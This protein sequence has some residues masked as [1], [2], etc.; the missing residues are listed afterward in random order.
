[1]GAEPRPYEAVTLSPDGERAVLQVDNPENQDLFIYDFVRDTPTRFTFDP[2]SDS[3]PIWTP[4]GDRVVFTSFRDR[5]LNLYWKAADGTG[6]V[7]RLT[8][9]ENPQVPSAVSPDGMTLLFAEIRG[10][11]ATDV[12]A[13]SLSGEHAVEWL[14]ES[15]ANEAYAEVSPDSRWVAY[16]SDESGLPEVYVRSYPNVDDAKRQ[17]SRNGGIAPR[18]GPDSNEVF[19]QTSDGPGTPVRLMAVLNETEPTFTPGIPR[20]LFEG[21]Y[22]LGFGPRP[23]PYDV[24]PDGQR[25][26]MIK[27][28]VSREPPEQSTVIIVQEWHEELKRLVQVD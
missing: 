3:F 28:P 2:S 20:P 1:M 22:R 9:S 8:T 27:E 6:Q 19:F 16:V 10:D 11:T 13:L 12:G 7:D 26:L 14:L 25:F 23:L 17:V 15:D 5:T 4:E 18:W 21:P 24:S